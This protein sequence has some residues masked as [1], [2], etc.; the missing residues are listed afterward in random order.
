[1]LALLPVGAPWLMG[2]DGSAATLLG[3]ALSL[4]LM[5]A[6]VFLV[7]RLG[8]D[9]RQAR[10]LAASLEGE[11]EPRIL[12]DAQGAVLFANQGACSLLGN[13]VHPLGRLVPLAGDEASRDEAQR[14]LRMAEA[15]QAG[16]GVL[17]LMTPSGSSELFAVRLDPLAIR[18]QNFL[19]VRFED[20]TA[21]TAIDIAMR[22]EIDQLA[23]LIDQ[24]PFGLVALDDVGRMTFVNHRMAE[25]VGISTPNLIGRSYDE[26]IETVPQAGG[27]G[28]LTRIKAEGGAGPRIESWRV[29]ARD[30]GAVIA[31]RRD[32]VEPSAMPVT[33]QTL[34]E[35]SAGRLF[36]ESPV[37]MAVLALDGCVTAANRALATMLGLETGQICG[38]P[39][40][41]RL[42]PE[43]RQDVAAQLSKL[44][45]GTVRGAQIDIRLTGA[46]QVAATLFAT[47]LSASQQGDGDGPSGLLLHFID[48]TEQKNLE[49]QF[50]Q[51]Q[52]MHAMGQ[53]AGGIAHDFNNLLTAMIGFCD[54]LLGRHGQGD[55]SFADIM[56]IKQNANRAASLVR[57]LL[58]FSRRQTLRPRLVDVTDS[59]SELSHLLRR[60][61][62]ET[63]ELRLDHGRELGLVR[64][65]PGQFEQVVINLAVNARDA[66]QGGGALSIRTG[67]ARFERPTQR[68]AELIPKGEYVL[69][70]V[71]DTGSGIPKEHIGRIFEPFFTTKP[72]GSGTGLG[73]STVYG[74]LKQTDGF[75]LVDSAPGQGTT[76][77]ILLPRYPAGDTPVPPLADASIKEDATGDL[78]GAGTVL[79]VEDED[80][81]R[82]FALRALRN[83]GYRVLEAKS[84]EQ[85]LDLLNSE[86]VDLLIT[87]VVM[88]GMD[89][90]TLARL[91][92]VEHPGIHLIL[93]SGY[94]EEAA[95]G[96]LDDMK[97]VHFL[98]KPFSLKQLAGTVKQVLA[99]K[100]E[101]TGT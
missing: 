44:V 78:S 63:I 96:K 67:T 93:M 69:I 88:P 41:E 46:R 43:D 89:G 68:G 53:L 45:M 56:Q 49:V 25:W 95:R 58:A 3:L 83:K 16:E 84:G 10:L 2:V 62:G 55:P 20:M 40:A 60:L 6:L 61:L 39:L 42:A 37:G 5:A 28:R 27:F 76:F 59:L 92:R 33:S 34:G 36:D 54:L 19:S 66:M 71:S 50:A 30:G 87:D 75:I 72:V 73:L 74:I 91:V 80:A 86:P 82:L 51:A 98:A 94:T 21:R 1:M 70:E 7:W 23:D 90:I 35:G 11:S 29:A 13:G 48:T 14:L 100:G 24:A 9:R 47:P 8:R 38:Q 4:P 99:R 31:I 77:T 32:G 57:Q 26:L 65:D 17:Q 12:L 81:V 64:V 52:K 97:D 15:R 18:G 22:T 101:K 85:A 79:L